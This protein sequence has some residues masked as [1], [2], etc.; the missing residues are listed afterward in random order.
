MC[1]HAPLDDGADTYGS[2]AE[3]LRLSASICND[4]V[5]AGIA[6]EFLYAPT[7]LRVGSA[8]KRRSR[9]VT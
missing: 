5:A 7:H 1:A 9:E 4:A 2:A 8:L 6:N 3:R